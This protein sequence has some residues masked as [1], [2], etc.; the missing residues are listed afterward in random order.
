VWLPISKLEK[1]QV[2]Q[3][4]GLFMKNVMKYKDYYGSVELDQDEPVI[5]G[6]VLFIRALISYEGESAKKLLQ[7]F[8]DAVDDYLKMCKQD[9]IE[10]EKPFKG[11]F[12]V[13]VGEKI[14][15]KAAVVANERNISL[16]ELVKTALNH[17]L[18]L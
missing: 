12:N 10:P 16:N 17:E 11:S 15:E 6:K 9:N 4:C 2:V 7:S 13:R 14:H 18:S 5:F 8:H 3:G 1:E